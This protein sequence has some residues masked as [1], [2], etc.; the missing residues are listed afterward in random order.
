MTLQDNDR[1][2]PP[3]LDWNEPAILALRR[4]MLKFAQ[5]QLRDSGAAEDAVQ[6]ALIAAMNHQ[7]GF[8]GRSALKTWVFAI[9]RNKIIDHLRKHAREVPA[10]DLGPRGDEEGPDIEDFFD[11]SGHW[12]EQDKPSTWADPESALA[13]KQFWAVFDACLNHL[14]AATARVFMMREFLELET[15]EICEQLEISNSNCWVILH[16]ART[17]LRRCLENNWFT[18]EAKPC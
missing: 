2:G 14:P 7:S 6:E 12:T 11:R 10:C 17:G 8:A 16:R 15:A 9:L 18:G 13:Q 3:A 1:S 5:L 4:D